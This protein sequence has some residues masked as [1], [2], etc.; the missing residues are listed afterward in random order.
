MGG[1]GDASQ[2]DHLVYGGNYATGVGGNGVRLAN[3]MISSNP[4]GARFA[5]IRADTPLPKGH[6][7]TRPT[8]N[9]VLKNE[10]RP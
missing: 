9:S 3:I 10:P 6:P 2:K 8:P 5:L 1:Y 7:E 4:E